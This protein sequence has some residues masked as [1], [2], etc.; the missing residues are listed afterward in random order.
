LSREQPEVISASEDHY[1]FLDKL[2]HSFS[3]LH[4]GFD[5]EVR[6]EGVGI[7]VVL[8]SVELEESIIIAFGVNPEGKY[9]AGERLHCV[10]QGA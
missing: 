5:F 4:V 10:L 2:I 8:L 7:N 6:A 1:S 3:R 9:P